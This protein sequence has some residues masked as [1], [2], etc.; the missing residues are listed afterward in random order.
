MRIH[1]GE[2]PYACAVC[3][4]RFSTSSNLTRHIR[5]IHTEGEPHNCTERDKSHVNNNFLKRHM[6]QRAG[7]ERSKCDYCDIEFSSEDSLAA[8]KCRKN[9]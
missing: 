5:N 1:T 2:R 3:N 4:K 8:H 6:L 7:E 9:K